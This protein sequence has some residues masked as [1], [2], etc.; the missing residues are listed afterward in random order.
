LVPKSHYGQLERLFRLRLPA[1]TLGKEQSRSRQLLLALI[2]EAPAE[3]E[4]A[5]EYK[6]VSYEGNLSTGE[7]VDAATIQCVV[8]HVHDRKRWWII[9]R[10]SGLTRTEYV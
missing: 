10:S 6:V 7:V 2:L 1:K 9:D 3:E 5:Y 4:E 8:G